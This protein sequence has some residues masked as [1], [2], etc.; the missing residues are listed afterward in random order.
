MNMTRLAFQNKI[1]NILCPPGLSLLVIPSRL[2]QQIRDSQCRRSRMIGVL[3]AG[4]SCLPIH[5][6]QPFHSIP[7]SFQN[8][9]QQ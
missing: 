7:A 8:S 1:A 4:P 6:E 2:G 5:L 3:Q 9:T